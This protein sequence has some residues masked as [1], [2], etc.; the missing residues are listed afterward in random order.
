MIDKNLFI[1]LTKRAGKTLQDVAD[2]WEVPRS[3]VSKRLN[4]EVEIKRDEMEKWMELVGVT[5]AGP[6]F[7]P[8]SVTETQQDP[9]ELIEAV[10]G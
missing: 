6:V 5:N 1:Y 7:F 3:S 4:G 9:L 8:K 10:N 2:L